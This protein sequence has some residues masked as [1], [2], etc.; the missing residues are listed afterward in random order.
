MLTVTE[1]LP[2][3]D[4]SEMSSLQYLR[5]ETRSR[6]SDGKPAKDIR[7]RASGWMLGIGVGLVTYIGLMTLTTALH[8]ML[9]LSHWRL[10]VLILGGALTAVAMSGMVILG[11]TDL[12]PSHRSNHRQS[13]HPIRR[14]FEGEQKVA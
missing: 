1:L 2:Q 13:A 5:M 11:M 4:H 8:V 12:E 6:K 7:D 14:E 3:G 9:D 10:V